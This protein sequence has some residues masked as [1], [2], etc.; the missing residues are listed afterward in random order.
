MEGGGWRRVGVWRELHKCITGKS[1]VRERERERKQAINKEK[2]KK[3]EKESESERER[4]LSVRLLTL[5]WCQDASVAVPW[6]KLED[7]ARRDE[8]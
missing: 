7:R 8:K 2:A 3:Q 6:R 5:I 4:G 1:Y